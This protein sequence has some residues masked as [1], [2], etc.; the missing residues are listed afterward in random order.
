[1]GM[2]TIGCD[3]H[4]VTFVARSEMRATAQT[5]RAPGLSGWSTN[6]LSA[7]IADA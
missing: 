4:R 7:P 5:A 6:V 2:P 3:G 1:M